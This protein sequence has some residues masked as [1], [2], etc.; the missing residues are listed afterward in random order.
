MKPFSIIIP[1]YNEAKILRGQVLRILA[2]L[3]R[4]KLPVKYEILLVDNGSTDDTCKIAEDLEHRFQT[5]KHICLSSAS[6]G[7]AYKK[8]LKL[9][10]YPYTF[11][12]DIDFWDI[13]FIIKAQKLLDSYDFVIGS[14][15]LNHSIDNRTV[16]RKVLSRI[17]EKLINFRFNV[18]ISDTHGLKAIRKSLTDKIIDK[19]V[20]PN[21]LFDSELLIRAIIDGSTF[22]EVPVKLEEIRTSR[23]SFAVRTIEVIKEF[24][25]LMTIPLEKRKS[26]TGT[27]P[28]W[29]L[30]QVK[31]T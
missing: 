16:I 23:F 8:G 13:K 30:S 5:V 11:Q 29:G 12:F 28:A 1:V 31:N 22:R 19:V 7:R 20:C 18:S 9:A 14:K 24:A 6:Y 4:L 3:E 27:V 10:R 2:G 17:L 15:N 25:L 21:H 26:K